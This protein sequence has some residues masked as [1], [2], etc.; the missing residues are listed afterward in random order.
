M[1]L[2]FERIVADVLFKVPNEILKFGVHQ[3]DVEEQK[4]HPK[5]G[6]ALL[7]SKLKPDIAS[8][9][10]TQARLL[11]KEIALSFDK[12]PISLYRVE[13]FTI[14][15]IHTQ[16]PIRVYSPIH[17]EVGGLPVLLYFHGGGFVLGDLDLVH[18]PLSYLS[19]KMEHIIISVDYRL[20]PESKF[21]KAFE[22]AISAFEWT[23]KNCK[24]FGGSPKSI[25]VGGDSAGCSLAAYV[26][27]ESKKRETARP[28]YQLLFYPYLDP[29]IE[30][31]SYVKYPKH[32]L[33]PEIIRYFS[34]YHTK[35]PSDNY[36]PDYYHFQNT[37]NFEMPPTIIHSAGFDPLRDE[38]RLYAER[39]QTE[40]TKVVFREFSSFIHAYIHFVQTIPEVAEA[41][42]QA[43]LDVLDVMGS[44]ISV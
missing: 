20:G 16:I 29:S 30:Y 33:T 44:S 31:P 37:N 35:Q 1:F 28:V 9:H 22:D 8:F 23:T 4:I 34:R 7:L 32:G 17:A 41:L 2:D 12:E 13:N 3:Y 15:S 6:L 42:D 27:M 19:K 43:A 40:G 26:C 38:A 25:G 14:P 10:P 5:M 36:N 39:L 18:T 21:P 24:Y 11:Y